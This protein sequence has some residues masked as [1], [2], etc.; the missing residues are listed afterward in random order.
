MGILMDGG[1]AVEWG[2][3]TTMQPSRSG[4]HSGYSGFHIEE[5]MEVDPGRPCRGLASAV[6]IDSRLI[7]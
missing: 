2:G 5:S 3:Q 1:N 6:W 7:Y 4:A